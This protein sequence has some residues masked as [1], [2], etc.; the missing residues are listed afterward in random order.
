MPKRL[1]DPSWKR[2]PLRPVLNAA[3]QIKGN[4]WMCNSRCLIFT[5]RLLEI[6]LTET[7]IPHDCC[8]LTTH[9]HS[10]LI[11]GTTA[12]NFDITAVEEKKKGFY[13]GYDSLNQTAKARHCDLKE[14]SCGV[15]TWQKKTDQHVTYPQK[16]R[17]R[18]TYRLSHTH[19][20]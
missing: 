9:V 4:K 12:F 6:S 16:L 15:R 14:V 11:Y 2:N 18:K 8:W 7:E 1:K 10:F 20:D 5:R 19:A 13:E 3:Y 17:E